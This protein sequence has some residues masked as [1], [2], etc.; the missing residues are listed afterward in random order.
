MDWQWNGV[1]T[2]S[3]HRIEPSYIYSGS[4]EEREARLIF[5]YDDISAEGFLVNNAVSG[6]FR[7]SRVSTNTNVPGLV[8]E[9]TYTRDLVNGASDSYMYT[10]RSNA[11]EI[12][13]DRDVDDNIEEICEGSVDGAGISYMGESGF[14][15]GTIA[16]YYW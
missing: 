15:A 14:S 3:E 5:S 13:G 12:F 16:S 2:G 9:S 7:S 8:Q 6:Q 10:F 11:A 4:I 1:M